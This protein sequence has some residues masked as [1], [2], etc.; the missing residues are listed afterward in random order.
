MVVGDHMS[1]TLRAVTTSLTALLLSLSAPAYAHAAYTHEFFDPENGWLSLLVIGVLIVVVSALGI[2][3]Y[4]W[5][6]ARGVR[7]RP[8]TEADAHVEL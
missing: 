1:F 5:R 8:S 7:P 4:C 6:D 3:T 2:L